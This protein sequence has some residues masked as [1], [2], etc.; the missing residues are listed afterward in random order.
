M[1]GKEVSEQPDVMALF[2]RSVTLLGDDWLT[3]RA[4]RSFRAAQRALDDWHRFMA[5]G[6]AFMAGGSPLSVADRLGARVATR[7]MAER[8]G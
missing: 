6:P 3:R 1:G 4:E 5:K 8:Y 7:D 2:G